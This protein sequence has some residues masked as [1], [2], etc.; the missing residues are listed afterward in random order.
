MSSRTVRTICFEC[1]S[2]CGVLL[3][4]EDDRLNGV[5]GDKEHPISRGYICPKGAA[6]PEIVHH[7][8]RITAP[9][10]KSGGV[11]REASWESALSLIAKNMVRARDRDG[12]ESVVFGSGTTRGLAPSMNSFLSAFGSPNLMA[13]SNMSGGPIVMGSLTTSGFGMSD[14]DFANSGS[15]LLWAHNPEKSWPGLYMNDIRDGLNNGAGLIVIDPRGTRLARKADVWLQIRP[16]TDVALAL[17]FIR[18]IIEEGLY[19]AE[20]V[21][22]WTE[23]FDALREHAAH[24]TPEYTEDITWVPAEQ[25]Q[26][27]ARMFAQNPPGTIGPGMGGVCQANDAFD[28]SRALTIISALCGYLE[29]PGGNLRCPAPTRKRSCYG[30]D[31]DPFFNLPQEQAR[32]KLGLERFPLMRFIPIPSPPQA[33]WPAIEE[34]SP[35]PVRVAGLFANNSVCAYPNSPRVR[36]A[37]H[38]LDFLFA[39]DYFHTPTTELADVILPPA[40]WA[41][42]DD[43]EDLLMKSYV[44]AQ[45]RAMEPLPHCRDE[46]RILIDLAETIG[47]EGYFSSEEEML[48]HRLEYTGLTYEELKQKRWHYG[49]MTYKSYEKKGS[50][51]TLTGKVALSADFLQE[52]GIQALPVFREPSESPVSTPDLAE[53]YPLVLTTGGRLLVY[54]H[55]S[56]RNIASLRRKAPDPELQIHPNTA[57]DLSIEDGEWVF[58]CSPRGRV[59]IKVR[60]FPDIHPGVVHSPHGF[61]YGT[62]NGWQRVNINMIT[63]DEDLCPVTGSVPIKAL[64]CRVEKMAGS[65]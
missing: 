34:H 8:E 58:L 10:V 2:R 36:S 22:N 1:H 46:K 62:E 56:H 48:D 52:L 54:Y 21:E 64:L 60:H 55:S 28:L 53:E 44:F 33:V 13:P 30:P 25:I 19:D 63:N 9:L 59:E 40:H 38:K 49:G 29:V 50:F 18:T 43:V 37:L 47:L 6:A 20:F 31:H 5:R 26:K 14:P 57:G 61:W 35:Y 4:I 12:P 51:R 23:G 24:Y 65:A 39:V 45:P 42:R 3:D 7:A 27:A 11:F 15:I 41:E 17:C 16:G 32:K